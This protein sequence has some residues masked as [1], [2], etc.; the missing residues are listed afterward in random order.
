MSEFDNRTLSFSITGTPVKVATYRSQTAQRIGAQFT[1]PFLI[2]RVAA[3]V[4]GVS[5]LLLRGCRPRAIRLPVLS[6]TS[7]GAAL[8]QFGFRFVAGSEARVT[9][10]VFIELT[11]GPPVNR[12]VFQSGATANGVWP[13]R[14]LV[15]GRTV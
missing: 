9:C 7:P 4:I 1:S 13:V 5:Q 15:R 11:L 10:H 6:G 12:F 2:R 3:A 14:T 8:L